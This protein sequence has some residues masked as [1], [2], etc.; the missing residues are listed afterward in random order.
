LYKP[1]REEIAAALG[2]TVPDVIAPGLKIL[3][4]GINPGLYSGA[5]GHHFARPGNRFWPALHDA[6]FSDRLLSPFDEH[7][8]LPLGCGITNLVN[9]ATAT[10]DQLEAAELVAGG[11]QLER[12][13]RR[14]RP[15]FVA[16]L[17]VMAYRTAFGRPRA[18]LGLQ[19]ERI[20]HSAV[21]ILPNPSGLNAHYQKADLA[22][23][24][25]ELRT[26]VEAH[27]DVAC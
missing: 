7:A 3:F 2:K 23:L 11:R 9:R 26:A 16:F 12:K 15:S 19:E 18:M 6:R 25:A 21:W 8:L 17:G 10:A 13:L 1:T 5:V 14:F 22:R 24:F 20:A 27:G 4:C